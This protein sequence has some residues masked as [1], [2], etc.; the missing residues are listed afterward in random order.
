L[1]AAAL[2]AETR[3]LRGKRAGGRGTA[4]RRTTAGSLCA[5][6]SDPA[7][8]SPSVAL[9]EDDPSCHMREPKRWSAAQALSAQTRHFRGSGQG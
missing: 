5:T 6:K 3:R 8:A 9:P 1:A 2:S 7:P 4:A